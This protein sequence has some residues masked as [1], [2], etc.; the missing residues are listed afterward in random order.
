MHARTQT[1]G[2]VHMR[3]HTHLACYRNTTTHQSK[4]CLTMLQAPTT[5][6]GCCQNWK[7]HGS[8]PWRMW[9]PSAWPTQSTWTTSATIS[10]LFHLVVYCQ[11][12]L[13]KSSSIRPLTLR[14]RTTLTQQCSGGTAVARGTRPL[15][16]PT[17]WTL[18]PALWMSAPWGIRGL[19][20][21]ADSFS[22]EDVC[23]FV[24]VCAWVCVCVLLWVHDKVCAWCCAHA[25]ALNVYD[26]EF[27]YNV[28]EILPGCV[29]IYQIWAVQ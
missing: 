24:C 8:S 23:V 7:N 26:L 16:S 15:P 19:S 2:L 10:S 18:P 21:P 25:Q 14:P 5:L 27:I 12:S 20:S 4:A 29:L 22:F 1:H 3:T 17:R 13:G 9:W 11:S 6:T 28:G